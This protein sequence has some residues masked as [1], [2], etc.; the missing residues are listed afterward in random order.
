[1]IKIDRK[2]A[3]EYLKLVDLSILDTKNFEI[4]DL[5]ETDKRKFDEI[6]NSKIDTQNSGIGF[7]GDRVKGVKVGL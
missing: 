4:V 1:M 6:E 2:V 5:I 3:D 7:S